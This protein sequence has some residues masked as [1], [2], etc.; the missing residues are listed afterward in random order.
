MPMR[1]FSFAEIFRHRGAVL[2]SESSESGA[3][4]LSGGNQSGAASDSFRPARGSLCLSPHWCGASRVSKACVEA[5]EFVHGR[6]SSLRRAP[7]VA[8]LGP[9]ENDFWL[10]E[11]SEVE[12]MMSGT[13]GASGTSFLSRWLQAGTVSDSLLYTTWMA[14]GIVDGTIQSHR[15]VSLTSE[16]DSMLRCKLSDPDETD[17]VGWPLTWKR[18]PPFDAKSLD[19]GCWADFFANKLRQGGYWGNSLLRWN[20]FWS[21]RRGQRFREL[22][23]AVPFCVSNCDAQGMV[24]E[25]FNYSGLGPGAAPPQRWFDWDAR[26][27][28]T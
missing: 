25:L 28:S 2:V 20:R 6:A 4:P 21:G 12:K 11:L 1:S 23:K 26:L 19:V 5:A 10:L 22:V 17:D 7:R 9:R 24:R 15:L 8:A 14:Q 18:R 3:A 16:W 27:R 13:E